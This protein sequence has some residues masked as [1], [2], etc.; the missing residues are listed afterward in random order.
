MSNNFNEYNCWDEWDEVD[1]GDTWDEYDNYTEWDEDDSPDHSDCYGYGVYSECRVEDSYDDSDIPPYV[2]G[3]QRL[4]DIATSHFQVDNYIFTYVIFDK[5]TNVMI[6]VTN[7]EEAFAKVTPV[8]AVEEIN[9]EYYVDSAASVTFTEMERSIDRLRKKYSA[10]AEEDIQF[11]SANKG[12]RVIYKGVYSFTY[13]NQ[14]ICNSMAYAPLGATEYRHDYIKVQDLIEEE[15]GAGY[16]VDYNPQTKET[17]ARSKQGD[18]YYVSVAQDAVFCDDERYVYSSFDV[19][20]QKLCTVSEWIMIH[21]NVAQAD[22]SVYSDR[23]VFTEEGGKTYKILVND[24]PDY[25]VYDYDN[26]I[27]ADA[28][29]EAVLD[30]KDVQG[31]PKNYYRVIAQIKSLT[32][33]DATQDE[34]NFIILCGK[35]FYIPNAVRFNGWIYA[36]RKD[37]ISALESNFVDID[38]YFRSC[39]FYYGTDDNGHSYSASQYKAKSMWLL[40]KQLNITNRIRVNDT[41]GG[42]YFNLTTSTKNIEEAVESVFGKSAS[43][44]GAIAIESNTVK[45]YIEDKLYIRKERLSSNSTNLFINGKP[46]AISTLQTSFNS[47]TYYDKTKLLS[48]VKNLTPTI[49]ITKVETILNN[50]ENYAYIAGNQAKITFTTSCLDHVAIGVQTDSETKWFHNT[51]PSSSMSMTVNLYKE[52]KCT[53]KVRGRT[54]IDPADVGLTSIP[55]SKDCEQTQVIT[56]LHSIPN[57][58]VYIIPYAQKQGCTVTDNN[59]NVVVKYQHRFYSNPETCTYYK[60]LSGEQA[61][62]R[63][64]SYTASGLYMNKETFRM[65][66][67]LDIINDSHNDRDWYL[68][69]RIWRLWSQGKVAS[70]SREQID[71]NGKKYFNVTMNGITRTIYKEPADNAFYAPLYKN[72]TRS[73]IRL[74]NNHL[75]MPESLMYLLFSDLSDIET[76]ILN[77]YK[78]TNPSK[79]LKGQLNAMTLY[80]KKLNIDCITLDKKGDEVQLMATEDNTSYINHATVNDINSG[81]IEYRNRE[82]KNVFDSLSK[83]RQEL[84]HYNPVTNTVDFDGFEVDIPTLTLYPINKSNPTQDD[85]KS[86]LFA[87]ESD[88]QKIDTYR[89]IVVYGA[90]MGGVCAAYKAA[91]YAWSLEGFDNFEIMLINPVPVPKLGGIGTVGGQ[92]LWDTRAWHSKFPYRGSLANVMSFDNSKGQ[93]TEDRYGTD[94]K[95]QSL[96]ELLTPY[97]VKIYDQYDIAVNQLDVPVPVKQDENGNILSLTIKRISRNDHGV[98]QYYGESQTING[99]IFIDASEDGKLT[100]LTAHDSNGNPAYTRGR[101]D[102][103]ADILEPVEGA[104]DKAKMPAVT[105][106]FKIAATKI[107]PVEYEDPGPN[108]H[109]ERKFSDNTNS[110]CTLFNCGNGMFEGDKYSPFYIHPETNVNIDNKMKKFNNTLANTRLMIKPTNS[111]WDGGTQTIAGKYDWWMNSLIIFG[112]DGSLHNRDNSNYEEVNDEDLLSD[113]ILCDASHILSSDD[114]WRLARAF[115]NREKAKADAG[116]ESLLDVYKSLGYIDAEFVTDEKGVVTGDILYVRETIHAVKDVEKIANGTENTNYEVTMRHCHYSYLD[117]EEYNTNKNQSI[118]LIYYNSD[119]HPFMQSNYIDNDNYISGYQSY[120]HIRKDMGEELADGS[121]IDPAYIPYSALT[122]K[123]VPNMLIPGYAVNASSFA[124]SEIRV[125]PNLCVLGDAAGIAAVTC[126]LSGDSAYG[127]KDINGVREVL[128]KY[129]AILDT[130]ELN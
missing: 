52:G 128:K 70:F 42:N 48:A 25:I 79:N 29:I 59:S 56:V 116:Q 54:T 83:K 84:F 130:D 129:Y 107:V 60:S 27:P 26:Y 105:L 40:S 80:D 22:I 49:S 13:A 85:Y 71:A 121:P 53:L 18:L 41:S 69:K 97:N 110:I 92:N 46:Y 78:I 30:Y 90:G 82:L 103:P 125:L 1:Y 50:G 31:V 126:L 57:N 36:E 104:E 33:L 86:Y 2:P 76:Y 51:A 67:D 115:L 20:I 114:A 112:V 44:L 74:V 88:I 62:K 98:I 113:E 37:V 11:I 35:S 72:T 118:G 127:L 17:F 119:I 99:D 19:Q 106:M 94:D 123:Y 108:G 61:Y 23:I 95:A 96:R 101:Y 9:G 12:T 55:H 64:V 32:G 66:M 43:Y 5:S 16:T 75:V 15:T 111:V 100:K 24:L 6:A 81:M 28:T 102:Y 91:Q 77:H 122:T 34:N 89:R 10:A 65:D 14:V 45:S 8:S 120:R 38:N 109:C 4:L 3:K 21:Y 47:S 7:Q 68:E 73:T 124:W 93:I 63:Q 58:M 117:D 39:G 87:S